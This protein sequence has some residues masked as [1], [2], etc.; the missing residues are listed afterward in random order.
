MPVTCGL[1]HS[2]PTPEHGISLKSTSTP[3]V[4]TETHFSPASLQALAIVCTPHSHILSP[5]SSSP[6]QQHPGLPEPVAAT[7][8][9]VAAAAPA[10]AQTPASQGQSLP[11]RY[12]HPRWQCPLIHRLAQHSK[13]YLWSHPYFPLLMGPYVCF[14]S[15]F[16]QILPGVATECEQPSQEVLSLSQSAIAAY[17]HWIEQF[18][19]GSGPCYAAQ[20]LR[21]GLNA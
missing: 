8:V 3:H 7:Y 15:K 11:C 10:A 21:P 4:G 18:H 1:C 12:N 16:L 14:P 9:L 2:T 13:W 5:L 17:C 6:P 19:A 20:H